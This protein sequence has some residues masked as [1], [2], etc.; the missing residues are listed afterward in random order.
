MNSID[1]CGRDHLDDG[2]FDGSSVSTFRGHYGRN[3]ASLDELSMNVDG[4]Y[5]LP[6]SHIRK[7]RL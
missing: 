3:F 4:W 5:A 1:G 7:F 6:I 2:C